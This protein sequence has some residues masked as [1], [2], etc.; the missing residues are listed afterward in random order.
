MNKKLV[1]IGVIFALFVV[2][3]TSFVFG[4]SKAEADKSIEVVV[5]NGDTL[6]NIAD[7]YH[8]QAGTS[9][10]ETLFYIQQA[11]HLKSAVIHPGDKLLIPLK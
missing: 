5:H 11:N 4:T 2:G 6:W 10:Q 7:K 8:T 1:L 9:V 3:M